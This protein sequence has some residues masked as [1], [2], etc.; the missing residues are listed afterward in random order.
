MICTKTAYR[1]LHAVKMRLSRKYK[2]SNKTPRRE[3][4]LGPYWCEQCAAFHLAFRPMRGK[5]KA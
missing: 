1:D 5:T 3:L 4:C 2:G